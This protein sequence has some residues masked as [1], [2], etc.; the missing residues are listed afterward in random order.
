MKKYILESW[1]IGVGLLLATWVAAPPAYSATG[2]ETSSNKAADVA[3]LELETNTTHLEPGPEVGD[4]GPRVAAQARDRCGVL[5]QRARALH[6]DCGF[7]YLP[8]AAATP[9]G[10]IDDRRPCAA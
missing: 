10:D 2:A 9:R 6:R 1:A 7:V 5:G 8:R 4:E 3:R